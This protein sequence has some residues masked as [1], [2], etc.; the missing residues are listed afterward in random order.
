MKRGESKIS[1]LLNS[2]TSVDLYRYLV[3]QKIAIN[4]TQLLLKVYW[5]TGKQAMAPFNTFSHS[6]RFF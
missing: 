6:R 5:N 3:A 2:N 1:P 4:A